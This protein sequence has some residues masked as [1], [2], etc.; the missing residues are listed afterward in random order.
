[1]ASKTETGV[2]EAIFAFERDTKNTVRFAEELEGEFD[3][4]KLGQ[5]YIP[6][7]TLGQ[8]G[9]TADSKVKVTLEIA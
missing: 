1:M 2:V 4:P 8:L 5:L 6:K 9:F 7:S 3:A